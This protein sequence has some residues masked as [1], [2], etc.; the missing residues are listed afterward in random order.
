MSRFLEPGPVLLYEAMTASR[1]WQGY[2]LRALLVLAILVALWFAWYTL[3]QQNRWASPPS[4]N[5]YMAELGEHFYYGVAGV[6]MSSVLLVAPAATAGAVCLDRERGWL[7]HMFVTELSDA[8]IVVGKLIARF[9]SI[10]ALVMAVVPVLAISTLLGGVSPEA[11][12]VLTVTSLAIALVGCSVALAL[13]VRAAKTHEVL[14]LVFALWAVWLMAYPIWLGATKSG[15]VS[16]PPDW[17]IKLNPLVFVYAPYV[18]PTYINTLDMIVWIV[19]ALLISGVAVFFA[20]RTL[21]KDLW[22]LG[23]RS[24]RVEAARRWI[25]SHLFSWWPT[26]S[27]DGN[28]VLWREWH[29]NRPSRMAQLV[30]TLFI[31]GTALGT[32]IGV[33]DSVLH[34]TGTNGNLLVGTSFIAV[35]FGL[36]LLSATAPTTLTEERVR[37]SLDVLMSTPVPTYQ[38]VLGKWWATYRR[39]LPMIILPVLAGLFVGASC[40]DYP[41]WLPARMYSM[42]RPV[43]DADRVIAG[44]LPAAFFLVHTAAV[45]SLGLALATWLRRT[46][47]AVAVSV[48][49]FVVMSIGWI[50]VVESAL[51]SLLNSR[52]WRTG[53]LNDDQCQSIIQGLT[54]LSPA[55]GQVTPFEVLNV[56][57]NRE[58]TF[59]W[60][61][62]LVELAVVAVV[63]LV[64]LGLTLLSFN[65]CMGRMNESPELKRYLRARGL[66]RERRERA[67]PSA[68]PVH[69]LDSHP[70]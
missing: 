55:G 8:E 9:A 39:T 17:F 7:A 33:A 44:V 32:V 29:R 59:S 30:S 34:G 1:R 13:S 47:V 57:W 5:Q 26:P 45:T 53:W 37:G 67:D 15:I 56:A 4:A 40:L 28:P 21:R 6:L 60:E 20:I 16:A 18:Y 2:A 65:R 11:L 68:Q 48:M 62:L 36:L 25:K 70:A 3:T 63:A 10:L 43:K 38:I 51:R 35:T 66:K 58:R 19:L 46:G 22:A 41:P 27:L 52:Q 54:A 50:V 23:E 14:M 42:A 31:G 12:I 49:T 61:V 69:I 24:S 64:F